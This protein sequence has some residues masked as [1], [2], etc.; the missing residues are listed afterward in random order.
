MV[1][2]ASRR[3]LNSRLPSSVVAV[4]VVSAPRRRRGVCSRWLC[5][6][7]QASYTRILDDCWAVHE[8][9]KTKSTSIFTDEVLRARRRIAGNAVCVA[10]E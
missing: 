8:S 4:G 6:H 1:P 10:A 5:G 2:V 3:P 7:L 9:D